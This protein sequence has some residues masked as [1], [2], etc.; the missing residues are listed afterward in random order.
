MSFLCSCILKF[1][2]W[3]SDIS[4]FLNDRPLPVVTILIFFKIGLSQVDQQ[5]NSMAM[6]K[7][8]YLPQTL[9]CEKL[10]YNNSYFKCEIKCRTHVR[11][12]NLAHVHY[13][14][15]I[16]YFKTFLTVCWVGL[17]MSGPVRILKLKTYWKKLVYAWL[18]SEGCLIVK[19]I[20]QDAFDFCKLSSGT[21]PAT[22]QCS[23]NPWNI[24]GHM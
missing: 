17:Y 18:F 19:H 8:R 16:Q 11:V 13:L 23:N 9:L 21:L 10:S 24:L 22:H 7:V 15:N 3:Q 20:K 12:S 4:E 2:L 14:W 6:F 1:Y 5:W